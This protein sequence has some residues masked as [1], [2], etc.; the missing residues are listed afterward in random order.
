MKIKTKQT[1][2]SMES[3]LKKESQSLTI[4]S[5]EYL[6]TTHNP[7]KRDSSRSV[8][9]K[10]NKFYLSSTARELK[11]TKKKLLESSQQEKSPNLKKK[12]W[13][14]YDFENLPELN[15]SQLKSFKKVSNSQHAKFKN[16]VA[17][18]FGRPK[19]DPA[20]KENIISIRFSNILLEKL[21]KR[22]YT[23]G[24]TAWQSFAKKVLTDYLESKK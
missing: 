2:K 18:H 24:Y 14:N 4:P 19:K 16:A 13:K 17:K 12:V 3:T 11:K 21:K 20:L 10:K 7:K 23:E 6:K 15:Q 22:A 9:P 8:V 1:S 5:L